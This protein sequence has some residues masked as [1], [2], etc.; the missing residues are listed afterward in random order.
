MMPVLSLISNVALGTQGRILVFLV[1]DFKLQLLSEREVKGAVYNVNPF[2]VPVALLGSLPLLSATLT[3]NQ[4]FKK[5][6]TRDCVPS[7]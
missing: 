3:P 7:Y 1:K 2:Q 5:L 4:V 6:G